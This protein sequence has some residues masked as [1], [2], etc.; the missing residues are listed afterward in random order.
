MR[1]FSAEYMVTIGIG[2]LRKCPV[3]LG[4]RQV[5]CSSGVCGGMRWRIPVATGSTS[6]RS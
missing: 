5:I 6:N 1:L 3:L 2:V 4:K